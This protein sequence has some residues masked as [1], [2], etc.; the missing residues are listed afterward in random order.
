MTGEEFKAGTVIKAIGE[1]VEKLYLVTKGSVKVECP[2]GSYELTSGDI[3]GIC[4]CYLELHVLS[5][6]AMDDVIIYPYPIVNAESISGIL[7]SNSNV[8]RFFIRS[9]IKQ[10]SSLINSCQFAQVRCNEIFGGLKKTYN[11]YIRLSA[12]QGVLVGKNTA[13]EE[14]EAF[15]SAEEPDYWLSGYYDGLN[16][17][18]A[19]KYS[20][21]FI[22]EKEVS[23]G[24]LRKG[25]LDARKSVQLLAERYGFIKKCLFY[26]FLENGGGL[27]EKL[28][29]VFDKLQEVPDIRRLLLFNLKKT[30]TEIKNIQG[31]SSAELLDKI[32]YYEKRL[33]E[34]GESMPTGHIKTAMDMENEKIAAEL[35]GSLDIILNFAGL[36]DN[37]KSAFKRYL[38]SFSELDDKNSLDDGAVMIRRGLTAQYYDLYERIFYEGLK[39]EM[40]V[41]VKM[42]LYF[43]YCDEKLA[44]TEN[45]VKLYKIAKNLDDKSYLKNGVYTFHDW[46][47]AIYNG[48]KKPSRNEF[49]VDFEDM[50]REKRRDNKITE[51]EARRLLNDG[52]EKVSFELENI[53][54]IAN[55]ITFGRTSI[56]CPVFC[57]D[58]MLKDAEDCLV[59]DRDICGK[60]KYIKSI[61]YSAFYRETLDMDNGEI[62]SR[63]YIHI[64]KIPDFV[65]M[66]NAGVRGMMWQEI[67]GRVRTTPGRAF[68][69]ILH[70][71]DLQ[72][73]LIRLTAEFRWE[74]CKRI[75]GARWNDVSEPSLTSLYCDYVQFY[76]KNSSLSVE[77]KEKIKLSLQR[78]RNSFKEMFVRDYAVYILYEGKGSPRLNK[79]ARQI[80]FT[81]CPFNAGLTEELSNNPTYL[82]LFKQREIKTSQKL[83][84]YEGLEKKLLRETGKI[85]ETLKREIEFVKGTV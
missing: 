3:I 14:L 27:F 82:E 70:M 17:I 63:E 45:A 73:T 51:P 85:P 52:R 6:V 29:G 47:L 25:C 67:E 5:Y 37:D 23:L 48:E 30:I 44:G 19:G 75:Q 62:M 55:K 15:L 81:Y 34:L 77:M 64:E 38:G 72:N 60:I 7:A 16:R 46:L 39:S 83:Q 11:I 84:R 20:Q 69:S 18:Y 49:D 2:G 12:E 13:I 26:Y 71:E 4:E 50:V 10:I 35:E 58:N 43:G 31:I 74:I 78:S 76:R 24:M 57:E 68:I 56:Y 32:S 79:V 40:P 53:F 61:D 42:F 41:Q 22:D 8:S 1:P 59:N 21:T 65:L 28:L 66:P 36:N 80:L 54:K 33:N 9:C